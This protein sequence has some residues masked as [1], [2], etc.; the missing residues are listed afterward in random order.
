MSI[1]NATAPSDGGGML[2]STPTTFENYNSSK[3]AGYVEFP[4]DG[5][6]TVFVIISDAQLQ[7]SSSYNFAVHVSYNLFNSNYFQVNY[8]TSSAYI[9]GNMSS[10]PSNYITYENGL[11]KVKLFSGIR[12][13]GQG[14][15]C[16][17]IYSV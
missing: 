1:F 10:S 3:S 14:S 5:M 12:F 15:E 7:I 2:I 8:R 9:K 4:V 6:P 13:L 17:L 11:L 16:R